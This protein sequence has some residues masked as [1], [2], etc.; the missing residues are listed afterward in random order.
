MSHT[1]SSRIYESILGANNSLSKVLRDRLL[2]E[3]LSYHFHPTQQKT[4]VL[5]KAPSEL[6]AQSLHEDLIK[7]V[8]GLPEYVV[9]IRDGQTL[10][11]GKVIA[12]SHVKEKPTYN[13]GPVT[14]PQYQYFVFGDNRNYGYGSHLWNS[15]QGKA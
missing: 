14:V 10:I 8:I 11:N 1:T 12:E 6:G 3:R 5:G 13:D 9:Q 4:L 2:I 7:R 15:C